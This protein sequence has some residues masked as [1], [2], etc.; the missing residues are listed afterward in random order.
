M[1]KMQVRIPNEFIETFLSIGEHLR[2]KNRFSLPKK[3][4]NIV[5]A[6][7]EAYINSPTTIK[8]GEI[9][10]RARANNYGRK[11]S[12]DISSMGA[13]PSGAS[14]AGRINPQG[15]SYLYCAFAEETAISEIRPWKGADISVGEFETTEE[16][17]AVDLSARP[18]DTPT[19]NLEDINKKVFTQ[20]VSSIINSHYFSAP[21]HDHDALAYL[22][23]QYISERFKSNGIQAILY[24]SAL[25][26][27]GKNVAFFSPNVTKCNSVNLFKIDNVK[28]YFTKKPNK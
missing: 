13:P 1:P 28:Y 6:F 7:V 11:D 20:L 27:T 3:L 10:W 22:A 26:G 8:K 4:E 12:Y 15:I 5:D 18:K 21:A 16:V 24:P 9:I 19:S 14:S 2:H 23:S 25:H 17:M